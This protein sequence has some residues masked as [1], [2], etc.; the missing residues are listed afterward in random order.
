MKKTAAHTLNT[1]FIENLLGWVVFAYQ[2]RI[3][4][5]TEPIAVGEF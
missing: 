2:V 1:F 3:A 4:P 5:V